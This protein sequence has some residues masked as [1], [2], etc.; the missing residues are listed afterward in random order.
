MA[1][2]FVAIVVLG[3]FCTVV[4]FAVSSHSQLAFDPEPKVIGI[5]TPVAVRIANSHGLQ[6]AAAKIEQNGT[7]IPLIEQRESPRRMTFWRQH[8]PPREFRFEAGQSKAPTLKEGKAKI[9]VEAKSNDLRGSV[10]TIS[11]D[12][13][14][15]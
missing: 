5:S 9:I 3:V 10:D 2:A 11:T 15:V 1:K 8:L 6:Y 12:V 14:V 4:L 13:D 7:I